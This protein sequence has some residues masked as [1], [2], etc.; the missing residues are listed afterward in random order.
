MSNTPNS[1]GR[2]H[3][4]IVI[5]LLLVILLLAAISCGLALRLYRR[6]DPLLVGNWRMQADYT[7]LARERANAWLREARLGEQTDTGAYLKPVKLP[8][9]LHLREDGTWSRTFDPDKRAEAEK[10]AREALETALTELVRLRIQD[11]GRPEVTEQ[12]AEDRIAEAIGMSAGD[13][14]ELYGPALLPTAEELEAAYTGSGV[15]QIEGPY[16]HLEGHASA[17]YLADEVLLVLESEEGTEVYTRV[18]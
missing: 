16:L 13:Y 1:T 4:V 12:E 14:L 10:A 11:A 18:R 6:S 3:K 8:V 9:E 15:Y 5:L 2:G 7:D 17:R